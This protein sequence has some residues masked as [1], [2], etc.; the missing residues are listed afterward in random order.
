[1]PELGLVE[2]VDKGTLDWLAIRSV[3]ES[4]D[5]IGIEG[6][7]ARATMARVHVLREIEIHAEV[8]AIILQ[9]ICV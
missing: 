1:M 6:Q 4:V 5:V 8:L 2:V 9:A 3:G 7:G